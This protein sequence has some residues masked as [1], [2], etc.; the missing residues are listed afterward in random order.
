MGGV[1]CGPLDNFS[2]MVDSMDVNVAVTT[3]K[4]KRT[5]QFVTTD[6]CPTNYKCSTNC[7]PPKHTIC[8]VSNSTV[9]AESPFT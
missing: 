1:L 4:T 8:I 9:T 6:W 5:T 7:K 2:R 3:I